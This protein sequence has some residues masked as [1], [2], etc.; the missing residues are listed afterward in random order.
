[1]NIELKNDLLNL[2]NLQLKMDQVVFEYIDTKPNWS[3]AY[4]LLDELL[5]RMAVAFNADMEKNEGAL[6]KGSTY[7]VLFMDIA[8]KLLYFT[9]LAHSHLIDQQDEDAMAH[10]VSLYEISA[11]CL[12]NA[13]IEENEEFITELKKSIVDIAPF[14]K[15][16]VE[17]KKATSIN[18]CI[19]RFEAFA[20]T[21]K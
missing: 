14:T 2:P 6:P 8:A 13:K 10:I 5:Q 3:K 19:A 21:Y 7:W 9:G 16:P 4:E 20:K 17:L 1:M 12:P 11:A 15:K 18:D